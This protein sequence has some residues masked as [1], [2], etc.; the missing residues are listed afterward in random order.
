MAEP[1]RWAGSEQAKRRRDKLA[2][3]CCDA[4]LE[5]RRQHE[6]LVA[7]R[8]QSMPQHPTGTWARDVARAALSGKPF[9]W[10]KP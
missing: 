1:K 10:E 8:D 4:I 3:A 2:M 9:P 7:I 5:L 6:A